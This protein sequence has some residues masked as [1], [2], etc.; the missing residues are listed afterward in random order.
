MEGADGVANEQAP[1]GSRSTDFEDQKPSSGP[2]LRNEER[3]RI[4]AL[5]RGLHEEAAMKY[6]VG[7]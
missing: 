2:S 5:V 3:E 6:A 1:S 7:V 4:V